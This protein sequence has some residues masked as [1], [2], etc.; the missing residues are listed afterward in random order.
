MGPIT[1]SQTNKKKVKPQLPKPKSK[2]KKN[3]QLPKQTELKL[4]EHKK[5]TSSFIEILLANPNFRKRAWLSEKFPREDSIQS[6]TSIYDKEKYSSMTSDVNRN[7]VY[8]KGIKLAIETQ[9]L[10]CP[11]QILEIGPGAD[12]VL[13]KMILACKTPMFLTAIEGNPKSATSAI[14]ALRNYDKKRFQVMQGNSNNDKFK[15]F[16]KSHTF[17]IL[18]QEILGFIA[19]SEGIA[20]IINDFH[21][22]NKKSKNIVMIPGSAATFYSLCFITQKEIQSHFRRRTELLIGEDYIIL[23]KLNF[24][25]INMF[26]KQMGCLEFLDFNNLNMIQT[27][28]EKFDVTQDVA[29]NSLAFF[30]WAGF[31]FANEEDKSKR[32]S[33][34]THMVSTNFP[35]GAE[36][37]L[38]TSEK[39]KWTNVLSLSS[40]ANEGMSAASNWQNK[41]LI[42]PETVNLARKQTLFVDTIVDLRYYVVKYTVRLR[43]PTEIL[44]EFCFDSKNPK[45]FEL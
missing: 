22:K 20:Y 11:L 8:Q 21:E 9:I 18:V 27:R 3:T 19:S 4:S 43:T 13:T 1:R 38:G 29:I 17:D 15:S 23:P 12:A 7:R 25:N 40:N 14:V 2:K 36:Q 44:H 28:T 34:T 10:N 26:P 35:Y 30:I 45:Y 42:L 16:F 5:K 37:S 32:K 6:A 33:R 24:E 41:V 39:T 31:P